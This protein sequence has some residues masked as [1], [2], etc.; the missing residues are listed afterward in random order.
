MDHRPYPPDLTPC[1]LHIFPKVNSALKRNHF[2]TVDEV[3]EK[4]AA[5]LK[6]LTRVDLQHCFNQWKSRMQ[7]CTDLIMN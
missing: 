4:M 1:D 2:Q 5:L 6:K 7:R 3:E